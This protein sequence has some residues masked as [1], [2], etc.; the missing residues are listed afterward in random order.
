MRELHGIRRPRRANQSAGA[1][2]KSE[3]ARA[4]PSSLKSSERMRDAGEVSGDWGDFGKRSADTGRRVCECITLEPS[5]MVVVSRRNVL[6]ARLLRSPRPR[7]ACE[8]ICITACCVTVSVA[9]R[10]RK[11]FTAPCAE[12]SL[13]IR[14]CERGPSEMP[15]L[16]GPESPKR[17]TSKGH[18]CRAIW[19]QPFLVHVAHPLPTKCVSFFLFSMPRSALG[20]AKAVNGP[21]EKVRQGAPSGAAAM[22]HTPV[23]PPLPPSR[24]RPENLHAVTKATR[25]SVCRR[26]S[27]L[28]ARRVTHVTSP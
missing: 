7:V 28:H 4:Q 11:Y 27:R 10:V 8:R 15:S 21:V 12:E 24:Q 5:E 25:R 17:L 23:L 3:I 6:P 13:R 26:A 19:K 16:R 14:S 1:T 20:L 18:L 9:L 22:R 2:L